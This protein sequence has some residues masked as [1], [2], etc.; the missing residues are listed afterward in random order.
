V[1]YALHQSEPSVGEARQRSGPFAVALEERKRVEKEKQIK[2]LK[3]KSKQDFA[4]KQVVVS[5]PKQPSEQQLEANVELKSPIFG[6]NGGGC[7]RR[8][9]AVGMMGGLLRQ[10]HRAGSL[11]AAVDAA[12]DALLARSEPSGS[13]EREGTDAELISNQPQRIRSAAAADEIDKMK[14]PFEVSVPSTVAADATTTADVPTPTSSARIS[15]RQRQEEA[16]A[17]KFQKIEAK[18]MAGQNEA[19]AEFKSREGFQSEKR[20]S[21]PDSKRASSSKKVPSSE[22]SPME[23]TYSKR[24]PDAPS[25]IEKEAEDSRRRQKDKEDFSISSSE[26]KQATDRQNG[27]TPKDS[28]LEASITEAKL[29]AAAK[30]RQR[31]EPKHKVTMRA[32]T[33]SDV[34]ESQ[35]KRGEVSK[36]DELLSERAEEKELTKYVAEQQ[37]LAEK[38]D[39]QK[40]VLRL[41]ETEEGKAA[42]KA[43]E[44]P[45]QAGVGQGGAVDADEAAIKSTADKAPT[46]QSPSKPKAE[47]SAMKTPLP[48]PP[49]LPAAVA[50]PTAAAADATAPPSTSGPS[51]T[52]SRRQRQEESIA[53]KL[54]K[55]QTQ[56]EEAERARFKED[57]RRKAEIELQ[58]AEEKQHQERAEKA[59]AEKTAQRKAELKAKEEERERTKRQELKARVKAEKEEKASAVREAVEAQK[60]ADIWAASEAKGRRK[61]ERMAYKDTERRAASRK[62][63]VGTESSDKSKS[64][65]RKSAVVF[66]GET[67]EE[68]D[69]LSQRVMETAGQFLFNDDDDKSEMTAQSPTAKSVTFVP[70]AA[71]AAGAAMA[72]DTCAVEGSFDPGWVDPGPGAELDAEGASF[73]GHVQELLS[74]INYRRNMYKLAKEYMLW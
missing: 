69:N 25:K 66:D 52:S 47:I 74:Q 16:A 5:P 1:W 32:K 55:V 22:I 49:V 61:A 9:G 27:I 62:G 8:S 36:K 40:E 14:H 43:S 11:A 65:S 19:A 39:R 30:R 59:K 60:E 58:V 57:V 54:H 28:S 31:E 24:Q 6:D 37:K 29:A 13:E 17:V 56:E 26:Q 38:L 71:W 44:R 63:S 46:T 45:A 51:A 12:D 64:K 50:V 10:A 73:A 34:R 33:E 48:A 42:Q 72:E 68:G 23:L 41:L 35:R 15:R 20:P 70:P 18:K 4:S 3:L 53:A 21:R 2:E 67:R 7:S